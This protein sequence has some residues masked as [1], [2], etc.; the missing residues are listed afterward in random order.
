MNTHR[1]F[2]ICLLSFLIAICAFIPAPSFAGVG[3][4]F[5]FYYSNLSPHGQW[6]VS[7]SYGRVWQPDVYTVGWNPYYDGHWIYTD[8]GWTWVSDYDWGGVPYHY[9]TWV[10]DANFGWVWVP[11]YV[12]APSWVVFRTGPDYIGW[13]PVPVGY[14]VGMSIGAASYAPNQFVFVANHDFLAPRVRTYAVRGADTRVIM[15]N[16]RIQN[17]IRVEHNVVVNSGPDVGFVQKASGRR[18]VAEPIERVPNIGPRGRMSRDELRA[19]AAG[20]RGRLHAA[21]PVPAKRPE[22]VASHGGHAHEN[23]APRPRG[24][25][26]ASNPPHHVAAGAGPQGQPH[27][28]R[29]PNDPRAHAQSGPSAPPVK[30]GP[31]K[32]GPPKKDTPKPH[33][34]GDKPHD[35]G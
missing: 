34:H 27:A 28:D 21:E 3:V 16:T 35:H 6:M 7:G 2:G 11:G 13:A 12:W 5:D 26:H 23:V 14:S 20:T 31:P 10:V 19:D 32:A 1:L 8:L 18:I 29:H 22:N 9:G 15:N 30:A 4:S 24:E 33:P 25:E 17:T